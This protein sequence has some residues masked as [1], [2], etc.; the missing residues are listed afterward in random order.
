MRERDPADRR[1]D[2]RMDVPGELRRAR[3]QPVST[4][5]YTYTFI[6]VYRR[7][8]CTAATSNFMDPKHEYVVTSSAGN[9]LGDLP[10]AIYIRTRVTSGPKSF[11]Y[12]VVL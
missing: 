1:T 11:D 8:V 9:S 2:R 3:N 5:C 10:R 6:Y 4:L 7:Y 12:S